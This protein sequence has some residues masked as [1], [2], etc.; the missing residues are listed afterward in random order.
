MRIMVDNILDAIGRLEEHIKLDNYAKILLAEDGTLEHILSIIS[1]G[2][3]FDVVKQIEYDEHID[4]EV[5][6]RG[7]YTINAR[8]QIYKDALPS[9]VLAD[10]RSKE[11]GIGKILRKHRLET[12]KNILEIGYDDTIYRSYE[13]IYNKKIAFSIRE[14]IS[15]SDA[16]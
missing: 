14:N 13:I 1:N 9:E 10:I 11:M 2:I 4:R 3:K 6:L 5:I 7:R 8:S 12:F 15:S 16:R